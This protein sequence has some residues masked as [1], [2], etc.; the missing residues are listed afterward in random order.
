MRAFI[1][2]VTRSF[3]AGVTALT[4]WLIAF[5]AFKVSFFPSSLIA[6]LS[7]AVIYYAIKLYTSQKYLK[8]H[9]LSRKEYKY[10]KTNLKEADKKINRLQRSLF[11]NK[12]IYVLKKNFDTLRVIK[13]MYA[14]TK[15]EPKRFYEA[16]QFFF[17]H[18]DSLVEL[19]EKYAFLSAQP[20]K[21]LELTNSLYDTKE[22]ITQLT[23]TVNK[24]F[25]DMLEKDVD[26]LHFEIDVAKNT[27]KKIR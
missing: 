18:L 22:M 5:L 8:Q 14:I 1:N 3:F 12:N 17:Y 19:T 27:L 26:H 10:I 13:K 6:L 24:D 7:G 16:E 23:N 20:A 4:V 11:A 25:Q 9:G 15:K 21:T 2:F